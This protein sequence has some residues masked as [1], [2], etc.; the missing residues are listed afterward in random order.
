[1]K[2]EITVKQIHDEFSTAQ[3]RLFNEA[4]GIANK[5]NSDT[6]LKADRCNKLGFTSSKPSKDGAEIL[7]RQSESSRLI[8]NI[9]Y[10]SKKYPLNKF[11]TDIEVK[12]ICEKYGLVFGDASRFIGEIPEKN[13]KEIESFKLKKED[14]IEDVNSDWTTILRNS[15]MRGHLTPTG[16]S[17]DH[18]VGFGDRRISADFVG[19]FEMDESIEQ[20]A[21]KQKPAFKVVARQQDFDTNGMTLRGHKLE[22]NIPDPIVLQPVKGGYLIVTAWGDEASDEAVVNEKMN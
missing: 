2:K 6:V 15:L 4:I 18:S 1:M 20:K 19:G 22:M 10:F 9:N 13:I 17:I 3:E 5:L 8:E 11:I 7:K 12:R 14:F 16:F 21:S